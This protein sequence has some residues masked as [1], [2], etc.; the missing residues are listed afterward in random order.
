MCRAVIKGTVGGWRAVSGYLCSS[1]NMVKFHS[2]YSKTVTFKTF[3]WCRVGGLAV[4]SCP[5]CAVSGVAWFALLG[6][7]NMEPSDEAGGFIQTP[8]CLFFQK[9]PTSQLQHAPVA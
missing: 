9:P 5:L 4:L 1:P 3:T 7:A 6:Q 2:K 8:T